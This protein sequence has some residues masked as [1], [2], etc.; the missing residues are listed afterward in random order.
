M[1]YCVAAQAKCYQVVIAVVWILMSIGVDMV[2]L[3]YFFRCFLSGRSLAD[4]SCSA[5][6]ASIVIS[7][8]N[9]NSDIIPIVASV[10][11]FFITGAINVGWI[12]V[13]FHSFRVTNIK[14]ASVAIL[15]FLV[16][17][18]CEYCAALGASAPFVG[19]CIF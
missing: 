16:S 8:V 4:T 9:A 12:A 6:L 3:D 13:A 7:F 19:D 17:L 5:F 10:T 18:A 11:G 1:C 15:L 2:A 14:A